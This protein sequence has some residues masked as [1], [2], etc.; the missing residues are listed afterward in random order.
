MT[1]WHWTASTE[2]KWDSETN[3]HVGGEEDTVI[4]EICLETW[5][6]GDKYPPEA[7]IVKAVEEH[8]ERDHQIRPGTPPFENESVFDVRER[9]IIGYEY[10]HRS[11]DCDG[12]HEY[13]G[14]RRLQEGMTWSQHVGR[15][16]TFR[17]SRPDFSIRKDGLEFDWGGP[18]DEGS[19][20]DHIK[21]I[22]SHESYKLD[23][24]DTHRDVFAEQMG[25]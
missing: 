1:Y 7:S 14:S 11:T 25:Y 5:L 2:I 19:E 6:A 18:T 22:F 17:P 3:K 4:C 24:P 10:D 13:S 9:C 20:S 15:E 23:E 12:P 8:V 16:F 21:A